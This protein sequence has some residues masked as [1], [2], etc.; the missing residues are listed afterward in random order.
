MGP[1]DITISTT[2]RVRPLLELS[3]RPIERPAERP[4]G[5]ITDAQA[6]IER[7]KGRRTGSAGRHGSCLAAIAA[8]YRARSTAWGSF[9]CLGAARSSR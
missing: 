7:W 2:S 9:Q 5:S 8:S 1:L 6:F 3:A 4:N